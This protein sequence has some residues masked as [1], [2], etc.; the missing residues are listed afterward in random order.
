MSKQ[1]FE[2][3]HSKSRHRENRSVWLY[4]GSPMQASPWKCRA[5]AA[6]T[7]A[8]GQRWMYS[9]NTIMQRW[10]LACPIR[11][12]TLEACLHALRCE[13][14]ARSSCALRMFASS[15]ALLQQ[16]YCSAWR[17]ILTDTVYRLLHGE[18][19]KQTWSMWPHGP[20]FFVVV[21]VDVGCVHV[22][23]PWSFVSSWSI[24]YRLR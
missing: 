5:R 10:L 16:L 15:A 13:Q 19:S 18:H 22:R 23:L 6:L 4:R 7:V 1:Y 14:R 12:G 24:V 21:V 8:D 2:T 17:S 9:C 20:S 3:L 11:Q